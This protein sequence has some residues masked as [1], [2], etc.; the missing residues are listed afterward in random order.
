M[1]KCSGMKMMVIQK[2][3][4][5]TQSPLLA[6]LGSPHLAA[7]AGRV[8]HSRPQMASSDYPPEL[9]PLHHKTPPLPAR[10]LSHRASGAA[11]HLVHL[12]R[13]L[14]QLCCCLSY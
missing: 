14:V 10:T 8:I 3:K 1:V 4:R 11:A 5:E 9:V 2:K 12:V 13:C 7:D 6:H